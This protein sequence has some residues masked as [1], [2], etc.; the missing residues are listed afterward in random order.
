MAYSVP[1]LPADQFPQAQRVLEEEVY[2][3]IE[4]WPNLAPFFEYMRTTWFNSPRLTS[5][6][7]VPT[8]T[9]NSSENFNRRAA[10]RMRKHPKFVDEP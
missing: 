4:N 5:V 6:Y 7:G 9:N 1:L 2:Q 3:F 8:R 10:S